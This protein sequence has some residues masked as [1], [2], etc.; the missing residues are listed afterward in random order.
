[1]NG[2][3]IKIWNT[4]KSVLCQSLKW[5]QP[6]E[7]HNPEFTKENKIAKMLISSI[8]CTIEIE[9]EIDC[10]FDKKSIK[11]MAVIQNLTEKY[12]LSIYFTEKHVLSI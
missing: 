12:V 4:T 7:N 2:V 1:M 5:I 10:L 3:V 8:K 11:D 6:Q 9:H